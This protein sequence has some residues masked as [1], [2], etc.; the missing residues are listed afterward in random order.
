[1]IDT[2]EMTTEQI[3]EIGLVALY[4]ALG[5][6]GFLRFLQLFEQGQGDYTIERDQWIDRYSVEELL[7]EAKQIED[8]EKERIAT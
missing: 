1:M 4:K 5:A 6:T 8:D 3:R 7:A 2:K